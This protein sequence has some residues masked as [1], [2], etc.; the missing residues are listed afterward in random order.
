MRHDYEVFI[1]GYWQLAGSLNDVMTL[2][3]SL[4]M[5]EINVYSPSIGERRIAVK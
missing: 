1:N 2:A 4:G 3:K 5:E